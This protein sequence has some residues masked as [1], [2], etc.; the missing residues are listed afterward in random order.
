[1]PLDL[2]SAF[3]KWA[4]CF[5]RAGQDA[6]VNERSVAFDLLELLIALLLLSKTI[7]RM[8]PPSQNDHSCYG[9]MRYGVTMIVT[10]HGT[11]HGVPGP[12]LAL[13]RFVVEL[14]FRFAATGAVG[15]GGSWWGLA[16]AKGSQLGTFPGLKYFK[17][18][19]GCLAAT[20][21]WTPRLEILG[22]L[23]SR[24]ASRRRSQG[25]W[26]LLDGLLI[27]F[28][29]AD[30]IC[31]LAGIFMFGINDGGL[32]RLYRILRLVRVARMARL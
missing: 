27:I 13:S 31:S 25:V 19:A 14:C 11:Y 7:S 4:P 18:R 32:M 23:E 24:I 3:P 5:R 20:V 21:R 6:G 12:M 9:G 28:C 29:L 30:A 17:H 8:T 16:V 22:N 10:H 2:N 1:M 26:N 15:C